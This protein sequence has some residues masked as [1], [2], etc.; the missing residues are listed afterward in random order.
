MPVANADQSEYRYE[1]KYFTASLSRAEVESI[2]KLHPAIFSEIYQPRHINNIYLDTI[3]FDCYGDNIDGLGDRVKARI[4]W[5]G[6]LLGKIDTPRLE[7]KI[8]RGHPMRKEVYALPG[9]TLDQNFRYEHL[10]NAIRAA[11]LP[12]ALWLSLLD[13]RIAVMNRYRRKYFLSADRKYRI[14]VDSDLE[15]CRITHQQNLF[16]QR[17][18]DR[19][20]VVIELKYALDAEAGSSAIIARLPFHVDRYSKYINGID[21]VYVGSLGRSNGALP[22]STPLLPEVDSRRQPSPLKKAA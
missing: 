21:Q 6:D 1:R 8:K 22:I 7:L 13:L 5:Y 3:T 19:S 18:I 4:R 9:F 15:Y 12:E 16:L 2:I 17:Q 20:D 11:D 14:T 10:A